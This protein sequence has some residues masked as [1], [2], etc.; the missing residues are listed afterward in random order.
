MRQRLCWLQFGIVLDWGLESP[1]NPRTGMSA[2]RSAG[3][4]ACG[5]GRLS[6]RPFPRT[7]VYLFKN[8]TVLSCIRLC[9]LLLPGLLVLSTAG[10]GTFMAHRI[11]QAPNT[12]PEWFAPKAPV[13]VAF[14]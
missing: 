3:F 2:L 4:P 12:Y 14:S 13:A 11:A 6:S 8:R 7:R 1:Q 9:W 5:L 10:C